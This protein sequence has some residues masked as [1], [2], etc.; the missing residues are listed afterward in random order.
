ME[1]RGEL[2][3]GIRI[4]LRVWRPVIPRKALWKRKTLGMA[5]IGKDKGFSLIEILLALTVLGIVAGFG[6]G[7]ANSMLNMS[8]VNETRRRMQVIAAKA[9]TYY[10]CSGVLPQGLKADGDPDS[11]GTYVPVTSA[12]LNLEQKYRLDGWGQYFYYYTMRNASAISINNGL[13]SIPINSKTLINSVTVD[14]RLVAGVIVSGGSDQQR[15]SGEGPSFTTTKD[16]IVYPIDVSQVAVERTLDDLKSLQGKVSAFE[17]MYQGIDNN[18]DGRVDESG[19]VEQGECASSPC[20]SPSAWS[21]CPPPDTTYASSNFSDPN[22]GT[23]TLDRM[24]TTPSTYHACRSSDSC[25]WG[26]VP[27][28]SDTTHRVN[29]FF[30]CLFH[31]P[32]TLMYDPWLR[33]YKWGDGSTFTSDKRQYHGFYSLG[34]DTSTENDDITP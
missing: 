7:L 17:A 10:R 24:S 12:Y 31:L 13:F 16:D 4:W 22:C 34:P 26:N 29:A 8:K 30:Y 33:V 9:V 21:H 1:D 6:I 3:D 15:Q 32:Q 28:N 25:I 27:S 19:C 18:G 5:D 11:A 23:A 14:T 20:I 2:L